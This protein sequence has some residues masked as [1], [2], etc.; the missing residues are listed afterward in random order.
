[1]SKHQSAQAT[2]LKEIINHVGKFVE[3]TKKEFEGLTSWMLHRREREQKERHGSIHP[4]RVPVSKHGHMSLALEGRQT[5]F[6][7]RCVM[8]KSKSYRPMARTIVSFIIPTTTIVDLLLINRIIIGQH[9]SRVKKPS[10][11]C[12][13]GRRRARRCFSRLKKKMSLCR[14]QIRPMQPGNE[15]SLSRQFQNSS[16]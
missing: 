7:S 11:M 12:K 6:Q 13:I 3:A 14:T 4:G 1:M 10:V 2:S 15:I 8:K 5:H 16:N 9:T